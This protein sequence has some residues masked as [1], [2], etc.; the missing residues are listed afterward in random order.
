[1]EKLTFG[2]DENPFYFDKED[3]KWYAVNTSFS[4]SP[5]EP[6]FSVRNPRV[7]LQTYDTIGDRLTTAGVDW[8]W[9][10]GGWNA[11]NAFVPNSG[12]TGENPVDDKFQYHHQP[13]VYFAR[14]AP[15]QPGRAHL[16][17]EQEFLAAAR[18]GTLPQ[19][20]FVKPMGIDNEHPGY[21]DV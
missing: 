11:A 19:V 6:S 18:A 7:P 1:P 13:F 5:P 16:K 15:G 3:G 21:A 8:A 10:S 14:Y 4:V 2:A 12:A 20:S 9:F 17:D